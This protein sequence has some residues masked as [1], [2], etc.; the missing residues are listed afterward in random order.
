M[1]LS[2][3]LECLNN[4]SY[5]AFFFFNQTN[6]NRFC[7]ESTMKYS[8]LLARFAWGFR[9]KIAYLH[10]VTFYAFSFIRSILIFFVIVFLP[11]LQ[12]ITQS[13]RAVQRLRPWE[14]T[15]AA[16]KTRTKRNWQHK[17][18]LEPQQPPFRQYQHCGRHWGRTVFKK[19]RITLGKQ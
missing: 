19:Q 1:K 17:G 10:S 7:E 3:D 18:R 6:N 5:L 15:S 12:W 14:K 4:S 11:M 16:F 13:P 8:V 9:Y 2:K